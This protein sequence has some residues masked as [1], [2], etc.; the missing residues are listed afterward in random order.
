[1]NAAKVLALALAAVVIINFLGMV[2]RLITPP[3]F[4][5]VSIIAAIIAYKII[6]KIRKK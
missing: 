6:P 1:M 3:T 2:F 4:W 5:L